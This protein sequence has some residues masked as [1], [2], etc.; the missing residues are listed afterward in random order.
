LLRLLELANKTL[1]KG[2]HLALLHVS[3]DTLR[4]A[5]QALRAVLCHPASTLLNL[6]VCSAALTSK[7]SVC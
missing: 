1:E 6:Q 3:M 4:Y 2:A 5:Q 7:M